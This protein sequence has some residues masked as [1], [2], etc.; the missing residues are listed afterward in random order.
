[1]KF[2]SRI[3]N[4]SFHQ[5]KA[6]RKKS[7]YILPKYKMQKRCIHHFFSFLVQHNG[8]LWSKKIFCNIAVQ[9]VAQEQQYLNGLGPLIALAPCSGILPQRES[10][11][12]GI[13]MTEPAPFPYSLGVTLAML[14][15]ERVGIPDFCNLFP[16]AQYTQECT[17]SS[18]A[19]DHP[20][21]G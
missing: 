14:V 10:F 21:Y 11:D 7:H 8:I 2:S 15:K 17:S 6:L 19:A 5:K 13:Q 16:W 12:S 1:M 9:L 18:I 20:L 3:Y 4:L